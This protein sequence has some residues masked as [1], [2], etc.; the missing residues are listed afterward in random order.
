MATLLLARSS[1]A[2]R[3][4]APFAPVAR[5]PAF[6]WRSTR[7]PARHATPARPAPT[8]RVRLLVAT[9]KGLW[10]HRSARRA[11][12]GDRRAAA[13]GTSSITRCSIR[14]TGTRFSPPCA[15]AISAPR[16][17][18]R[19]TAAA[20]GRS[21]EPAGVREG[22]RARG[23]S[24]VL[25]DAG[26]ASEPGVWYAGTSPQGLF[27]SGDGGMTWEPSPASTIIRSTSLV[28]RRQGRH[29]RRPQAAFD[30]RRP[31][32]R[33]APLPRHVGRRGVRVEG[34]RRDWKPLNSGVGERLPADAEYVSGHDPHCVR[35]PPI[36][37]GCASRT[38]A[39]STGSIGRARR[40]CASATHAEGRGDVG[41]PLVVHPRDP[42]TRGC[43]RWTAPRCGRAPP[44]A[45]RRRTHARWRREWKRH[46][47][48]LPHE[49]AWWT[50]KRQA[51]C[52]MRTTP[53]ASTSARPGEVWASRDEGGTLAASRAT[54][55]TS[56][57]SK[58]A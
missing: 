7:C 36:R 28:R 9:R 39:A 50:V 51:M 23:R 34:P 27:R 55:R 26:P 33:E 37:I 29:A 1:R 58:P 45:S 47:E 32:R 25:A 24:R 46:D 14:V 49:Q 3:S 17:F 52:T 4:V 31:A 35:L 6:H 19:P 20:P 12:L 15:P 10:I 56:T 53:S 42:D 54:C 21:A 11:S 44:G 8:K 16:C 18:A 2:R 41:F 30:H 57:R 22:E 38:T 40:G 48:G 5:R 13:P 43:S